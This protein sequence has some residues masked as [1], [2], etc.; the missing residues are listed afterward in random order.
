MKYPLTQFSLLLLLM[1]YGCA[2]DPQ[3]AEASSD[4][5]AAPALDRFEESIQAYEEED[6]AHPPA[7]GAIVFT[8][9]SSIRMW[10]SLEEDMAPLSVLNRGFGGSTIPEVTHYAERIIA[11]Y[12]PDCIVLYGGDNDISSDAVTPERVLED[13]KAYQEK[14]QEL[15][16]GTKTYFLSIKPSI[17]RK[18][19]LNKALITNQ[20]V[21]NYSRTDSLMEYIDVA[22]DMLEAPQKI[23][24][25]IFIE[26]SLHMNEKGYA[27]W[28]P[29]VKAALEE[30]C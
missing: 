11:P 30:G 16:P 28:A 2:S 22:S 21:A 27:I 23:R 3:Q 5:P 8:G 4:S 18:H 29:I 14:V 20:L 19:L 13:L 1:A 15:L 17:R 25:D 26:D 24:A 12:E 10:K 7:A 6:Q 9:S